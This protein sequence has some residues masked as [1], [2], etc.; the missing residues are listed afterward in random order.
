MVL[1]E[2]IPDL[3]VVREGEP[4]VLMINCMGFPR[5]SACYAEIYMKH[6]PLWK[7]PSSGSGS[8]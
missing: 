4:V 7:S 6:T 2:L 8:V 5:Q 3:A 1:G